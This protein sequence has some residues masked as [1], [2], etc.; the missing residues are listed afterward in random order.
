MSG[1]VGEL[2][3]RK[4]RPAYVRF[5][6]RAVEDRRLKNENGSWPKR[7]VDYVLVTPPYSKDCFEQIAGDWFDQMRAE[8]NNGRLP[9]EW[10]D[11]YE[12]MFQKWQQGQ[13]LP[14]NGEPIRGWNVISPAKQENLIAM[15]I[16]TVEDLAA[17]ND[18]GKRRIGMGAS[19]L[20]TKA[21]AWLS[22][23]KDKGP[24]TQK[25]AEVE[26]SNAQLQA[27]NESLQKRVSELAETVRQLETGLAR[28]QVLNAERVMAQA[29]SNVAQISAADLMPDDDQPTPRKTLTAKKPA[30]QAI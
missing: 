3:E 27:Q 15:G 24:L 18:E 11:R 16:I 29:G 13:E 23:M 30:P 19:E 1:I 4:D 9:Q 10:F 2:A 22:Q 7:D 21:K 28:S 8:V 26:S 20:V 14:P 12:L 17:A 25:I 6:R 5:Q